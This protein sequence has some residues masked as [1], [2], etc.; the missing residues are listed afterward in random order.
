MWYEEPRAHGTLAGNWSA[1]LL[2][3][4]AS[5]NAVYAACAITNTSACALHEPSIS[6]IGTRVRTLLDQI[7]LAP[8]PVYNASSG[9][10]GVAD[11]T[12]V[13]LQLFQTLYQPY[14]S[15]PA[16]FAA[17]RALEAGDAAPIFAGSVTYDNDLLATC[18]PAFDRASGKFVVGF[19]DVSAPIACG[20]VYD[21]GDRIRSRVE[22]EGD[23]AAMRRGSVFAE[24]WYPLSQ[25]RC[26]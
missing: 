23:L 12:V 26:V 5:L 16:M 14:S 15:A 11:Y 9:T 6:A 4:D 25:G 7:H 10:F 1:S 18:D 3:T 21:E 19:L 24:T 20:D 2:D 17:L 8:Q 13:F 22:A